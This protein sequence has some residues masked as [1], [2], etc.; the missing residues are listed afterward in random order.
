MNAAELMKSVFAILA[1]F[2][3]RSMEIKNGKIVLLVAQ[4]VYSTKRTFL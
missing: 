1:F 2:C 3:V 4:T